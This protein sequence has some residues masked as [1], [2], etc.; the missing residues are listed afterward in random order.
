MKLNTYLVNRLKEVF[1]EGK[2]VT[3][4]NFKEQIFD[5]NWSDAAKKVDDLNS[6]A[7]ITFHI[8]Y[9]VAGVIKV[10]EG[11]PLEIRD[12]FSFDAPPMKSEKAWRNLVEKFISDSEK[13]I[14]FVERMTEEELLSNF[15]DEKYGNYYRNIDLMIEHAYYHLGQILLIKKLIRNG[16]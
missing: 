6:I 14:H 2:W 10:F 16:N 1:T 8:N 12:K 7:D 3:G 15:V 13:F 5:L 9:Y 11:G 4:T